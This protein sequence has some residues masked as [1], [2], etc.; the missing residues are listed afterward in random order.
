MPTLR[1][2][3]GL[4][5]IFFVILFV[6]VICFQRPI[7]LFIFEDAETL[8]LFVCFGCSTCD[9]LVVGFAFGFRSRAA[10]RFIA[11]FS[12]FFRFFSLAL[13]ATGRDEQRFEF[14][15]FG[16]LIILQP[17][18]FAQTMSAAF[19]DPSRLLEIGGWARS[20]ARA[21]RNQFADDDIFFQAV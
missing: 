3:P 2:C 6:L 13:F 17:D 8:M 20:K 14:F 1:V 4:P 5:F 9:W 21:C 12:R 11:W 18:V 19:L 7:L 16:E 15:R 10:G